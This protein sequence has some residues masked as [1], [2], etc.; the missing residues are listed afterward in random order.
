MS[1]GVADISVE[2]RNASSAASVSSAK[3]DSSTRILLALVILG[4]AA[5]FVLW[6][7]SYGT[8]DVDLWEKV[9][10]G[11]ARHGI[12][13][14]YIA[15]PDCNQPPGQVI[16][17]D[18]ACRAGH[19]T[20]LGFARMFKLPMVLAD[21]I[22]TLLLWRILR[23]RTGLAFAAAVGAALYAWSPAAILLSAHHGNGDSV[24]AML[25]LLAV[26][27][28]DQRR[29]DF[30][31][32]LALGAAIN[33]KLIPVL[34]IPPLLLDFREPRRAM[35]L[36]AGLAIMAIPSL[37]VLARAPGAFYQHVLAY[38]SYVTGWGVQKILLDAMKE[39][40]FSI[41]AESLS[42]M[43][44]ADGRYVVL[45]AVLLL[46][47]LQWRTRKLNRY[48]LAS[49]TMALF[50]VLTPGFGIQY[51]VA[52]I[53]LMF[54]ADVRRATVF[55]LM[56]ALMLLTA[57]VPL[58]DGTLPIRTLGSWNPRG[59]APTFGLLAWAS[60][61]EFTFQNFVHLRRREI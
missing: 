37:I 8:S 49:T 35:R 20:H 12:V 47:L 48:Q 24:Y 32:G 16:W 11:C 14:T 45:G 5:R 18:A 15:D 7:I 60:L 50:L 3:L 2:S 26:Y 56:A 51:L 57:Y 36:L 10:R 29:A 41:A 23:E 58:W 13:A 30:L 40:A 17:A 27:L 39:P 25:A 1:E 42:A 6:S 22:V 44:H 31:G 61:V 59:L 34:L 19:A 4:I 33:V 46:A 43:Y 38:N 52:V 53:P 21:V 54:A 55:S 28:I 9:G